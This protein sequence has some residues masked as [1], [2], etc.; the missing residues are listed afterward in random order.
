MTDTFPIEYRKQSGPPTETG[1]WYLL[2]WNEIRPVWVVIYKNGNAMVM[3][4]KYN[5]LNGWYNIETNYQTGDR[6]KKYTSTF[7]WFGPALIIKEKA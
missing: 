4:S 6:V 7:R 5:D 2:V 3:N 1:W